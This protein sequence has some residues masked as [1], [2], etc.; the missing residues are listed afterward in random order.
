[1]ALEDIRKVKFDKLNAIKKAGINPFPQTTKRTHKI[2][3]AIGDFDKISKSEKEIIIVGR[4]LS[5][6]EHGGSTFCH[7]SD[8]SGQIQI[9]FK[10]DGIGESGYQFFL[11]NFDIGDFVEAK[12]VVFETKRGEKTIL[13]S[14]F[15]MLS[16]SILPLPEKWHGLQDVEE[17]FR[18]RYLDLIMNKEV[19]E[20]FGLRSKILSEIR[21]YLN[22]EGFLEM[23]TPILQNLPGGARAKP[24]KTHLNALNLDL[25]M[26]IA[27]E[28]Y[29][30]RLLVGGF[31]KIY[32]IGRCFRNEGMDWSHN[33]DFTMFELYWA[34]KDYK[35]LMKFCEMFFEK[36]IEKIFGSTKIV[37]GEKEINFKSP[38]QRI[39]FSELI[40][41][42]AKIKLED[43]S[44]DAL[45]K[46]AEE[47]GIEIDKNENKGRIADEIFKKVCLPNLFQPVFIIHQPIELTPLA[48]SLD[49]NSEIAARFQLVAG[50]WELANG[51]S[52]L[53]DS[54]IQRKNFEREEIERSGGDE[55]AQR[56]DYDF[57][58]ALE[59]G[60]PPA[61]G[62][63]IGIDRLVAFLTDSHSLR[64]AM[65]FPTMK[66][67]Q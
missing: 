40:S 9:Y 67:R 5:K 28:L 41:K 23:E 8:G 34:Y 17:R 29:L 16:K 38:W 1:M 32:E 62:W 66:P 7:I 35:E 46:K 19:F 44:R 18:K 11:D 12:G 39:E 43:V 63:G 54:W 15:K 50:G 45:A 58:E 31:E 51:F 14:D 56:F 55:E 27:P 48:K 2:S 47:L 4:I 25:Y 57:V 53:N 61:A 13:V 36:L 24:F 6:R 20:K 3:D 37:Y 49:N 10:K 65:L 52:E 60:M 33:P 59:Y 30:K 64:E 22:K 42:Y 21:S 26:R